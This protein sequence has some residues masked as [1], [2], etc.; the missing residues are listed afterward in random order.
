MHLAS[1]GAV[2]GALRAALTA[3]QPATQ[4]QHPQRSLL[5][6]SVLEHMWAAFSSVWHSCP[7]RKPRWLTHTHT[8]HC[9][10]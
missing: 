10:A 6:C 3:L 8:V 1:A 9:A 2:L 5:C 7:S 4:A